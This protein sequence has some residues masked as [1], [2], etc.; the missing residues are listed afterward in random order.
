MTRGESR[1]CK[2]PEVVSTAW[3]LDFHML[4]LGVSMPPGAADGPNRDHKGA[5]PANAEELAIKALR[6][7]LS[8]IE[9]ME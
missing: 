3:A 1:G 2:G 7:N 5:A 9:P 4:T 8:K 6:K